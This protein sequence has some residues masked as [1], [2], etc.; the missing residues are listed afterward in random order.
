MPALYY[1]CSNGNYWSDEI[2]YI[3]CSSGFVK[4][5]EKNANSL[6]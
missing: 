1:T 3:A 2:P 6:S 5:I 4:D